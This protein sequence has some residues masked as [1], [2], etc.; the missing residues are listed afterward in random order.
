M[1]LDAV[2][3]AAGTLTAFPVPAPRRLD[4]SRAGLAMALAPA[5]GVALLIPLAVVVTLGH[6]L[7]VPPI[8]QSCCAVVTLQ[9]C[10]RALHLDGLADTVDGLSASYER[11]RALAVMH[12]GDVGP[13][14]VAAIVLTLALQ[15]ACGSVLLSDH[16]ALAAVTVLVGRT[17]LTWACAH[18]IPAARPDGLG[19]TVAGSVSRGRAAVVTA[20]VLAASA[21]TSAVA[22]GH[23]WWGPVTVAAAALALTILVRRCVVRLGGVSGD[24]LGAGVEIGFAASLLAATAVV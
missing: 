12:T 22:A 8:V 1:L 17:T 5:V 3:L 21:I 18:G 20:A 19:A 6:L 24:V 4:R 10:T 14:G 2:R 11:E 23:W 9:L 16:V 7:G 13:S 15:V